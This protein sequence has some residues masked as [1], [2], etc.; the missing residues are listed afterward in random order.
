MLRLSPVS[1]DIDSP[2]DVIQ[3]IRSR[4]GGTLFDIDRLLLHSP[5]FAAGWTAHAG[6]VR[7][8]LSLEPRLRELAIVA[9]SVVM[10][11]HYEVAI[12]GR[13][14]LE[15]G[16][17]QTQLEALRDIDSAREQ[18][19]L[20]SATERAAI[21]LAIEMTRS[22]R[23]SDSTFLTAKEAMGD[24]RAL[25]ELIGVIATYN[26]TNRFLMAL[27]FAQS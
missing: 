7:S 22:I 27:N 13:V 6:A 12:H 9:V 17:S 4:R 1:A 20:F 14:F 26:M 15:A 2:P 25:V 23:V 21:A 10:E 19:L 24:P 5:A 8:Q 18:T 16:G 11:T 3:A